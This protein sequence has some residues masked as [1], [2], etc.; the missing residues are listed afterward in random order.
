MAAALWVCSKDWDSTQA[1][2]AGMR[3]TVTQ[4][5]FWVWSNRS[6]RVSLID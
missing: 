5:T 2:M 6:K 3:G 1:C 4:R